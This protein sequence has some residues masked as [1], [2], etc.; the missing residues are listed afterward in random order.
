M[1]K[2][3]TYGTLPQWRR[4]AK[5]LASALTAAGV[6]DVECVKRIWYDNPVTAQ[7][8]VSFPIEH[9]STATRISDA[10]SFPR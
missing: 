5:R 3:W 2:S 1:R 10:M 9:A 6:P 7:W 4:Y 8:E